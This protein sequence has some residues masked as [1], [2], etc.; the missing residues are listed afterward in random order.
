MTKNLEKIDPALESL[1][2]FAKATHGI[3]SLVQRLRQETI[4][5]EGLI[6]VKYKVLA[7][8]LWAISVRCEPCIRFYIQEATKKGVTEAELSEF[9]SLATAMGACVSEMWSLK[10]YK[11]YQDTTLANNPPPESCCHT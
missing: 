3:P 5:K 10:A 9:L 4:F 6:S 11:T 8:V 7:C 1:K 2:D